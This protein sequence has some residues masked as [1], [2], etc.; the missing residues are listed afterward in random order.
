LRDGILD[1]ARQGASLVE[2]RLDL[3]NEVNL[4][5][6]IALAHANKIKVISTY[7]LPRDG[8]SFNGSEAVRVDKIIEAM[9]AGSDFADLEVNAVPETRKKV[10]AAARKSNC[11][12]V[13]SYH[14]LRETPGE[15]ELKRIVSEIKKT[16]SVGKLV[17]KADSI[18]ECRELL[19]QVMEAKPFPLVA[20]SLGEEWRFTRIACL[21]YGSPFTYGFVGRKIASGQ[22]SVTEVKKAIDLL[23]LDRKN[24]SK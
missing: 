7:R 2:L 17:C 4:R 13:S 8:G 14:N 15:G 5:E 16:G 3:A 24:D 22:L 18:E 9:R 11:E 20:F 21:A 10:F 19:N 12:I 23:G 6:K 1:A